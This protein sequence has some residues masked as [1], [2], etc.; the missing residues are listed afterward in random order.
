MKEVIR[1]VVLVSLGTSQK[2]SRSMLTGILRCSL[3]HPELEIRIRGSLTE[4]EWISPI[5]AGAIVGAIVGGPDDCLTKRILAMPNLKAVVFTY[6]E[7]PAAFRTKAASV[8]ADEQAIGETA[9][10]LFL[11]HGLRHFAYVSALGN[12]YWDHDR[13]RSFRE[14]LADDG[15]ETAVYRQRRSKSLD[16][17]GLGRWLKSLPSPCG[18]FAANDQL[19]RVVIDVCRLEKLDIPRRLQVL[20]VDDEDFICELSTPTISSVSPDFEA[21]GDMALEMLNG[22]LEGCKCPERNLKMP[23]QAVVERLSTTDFTDSA[24]RVAVARE[25]I[26]KHATD[27]IGVQNV[28]SQVVGSCRMLEKD[29]RSILGHTIREEII[30]TRLSAVRRLLRNSTVPIDQIAAKCGFSK[31]N[32]LKNIFRKRYGMTMR[33]YRNGK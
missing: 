32:Y 10:N 2:A 8:K 5:D 27:G 26:R 16:M 15:F 24:N 7:I 17:A 21:G 4:R 12:L 13:E 31:G 29:F 3:R 18:V 22:L 14:T 6:G 20:G 9:A 30:E 23:V 33:D 28:V 11:K 1:K 25:Y 19:A